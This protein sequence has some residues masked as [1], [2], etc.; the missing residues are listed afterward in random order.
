MAQNMEEAGAV[1]QRVVDR[2]RVQ[3][4]A[5]APTGEQN[6]E[7]IAADLIDHLWVSLKESLATT[8]DMIAALEKL[9]RS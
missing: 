6:I 4:M 1:V 7:T 2:L 8:D 3:G 5:V 9:G